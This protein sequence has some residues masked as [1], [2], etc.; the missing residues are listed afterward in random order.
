MN[1]IVDF[2]NTQTTEVVFMNT[3]KNEERNTHE[4]FDIKITFDAMV[5]ANPKDHLCASSAI[6][7]YSKANDLIETCLNDIDLHSEFEETKTQN[8]LIGGFS[9]AAA[10]ACYSALL[11]GFNCLVG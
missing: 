3:F 11:F 6:N 2:K 1:K 10:T 7:S 8:F 5:L 4:S 9:V